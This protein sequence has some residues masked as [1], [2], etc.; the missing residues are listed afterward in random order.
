TPYEFRIHAACHALSSERRLASTPQKLLRRLAHPEYAALH[1]ALQHDSDYRV[2]L[3][4][5]KNS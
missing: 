3:R 4:N 1:V 2:G 5:V